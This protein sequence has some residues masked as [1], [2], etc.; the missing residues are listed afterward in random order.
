MGAT[1][2]SCIC[3]ASDL[4]PEKSIVKANF[5]G[6]AGPPAPAAAVAEAPEPTPPAL[7]KEVEE[8]PPKPVKPAPTTPITLE[9]LQGAWVNSMGAKINVEDT[10]VSL[11]GLPMRVHP[12]RVSDD[13]TVTSIGSIWQ[14]RGWQE[15]DRIEFKECPSREGMEFARSVV[16]TRATEERMTE[17]QTQMNNL[18]YA[19]SS[20]TP[21]QRS[22]EGCAPGTCDAAAKIVESNADKDREELALLNRLI[23]EYREPGMP[24]VP[25]SSVIPDF[26]NRGHTGLSVEHVHYLA[27]SFR[28]KGFKKRQ[29]NQGHDIPVLVR[30]ASS[31]DLG[32]KSIENWRS[33]VKD[34]SGFPPLAH[35]ERA[36]KQA[37]IYT[38]LGNGHF[39]QALNLFVNECPS[40]YDPSRKYIVGSDAALREATTDGVASIVLR[41]DIP[42]RERETISKL[43]NSKREYK[44]NVSDD[45]SVNINDSSEDMSQCKQFEALSKVLDAVELNCLVRAELGVKDSQRIGQ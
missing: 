7:V 2:F 23:S 25:P 15:D 43:L 9:T 12:V 13:G 30:E 22:V 26:S 3:G 8:V 16:W 20:K 39:N 37:T 40:I 1:V 21:L 45:G 18:G 29:G 14:L 33:K 5:G 32:G 36:F 4:R 10:L 34:E 31:S 27:S 11:N 19:G 42:L 17:W 35:Y 44:W 41:A 6:P 38:S 24:L 28:D